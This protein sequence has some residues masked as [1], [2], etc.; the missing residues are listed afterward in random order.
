MLLNI[1]LTLDPAEYIIFRRLSP[2]QYNKSSVTL[3]T[4]FTLSRLKR[5][6]RTLREWDGPI[7]VTIYL[8]DATDIEQLV[9]YLATNPHIFDDLA[10]TIVKPDYSV[11]EAA[12][13]QRLRYPI[14]QLRNLA[15]E[16]APTLYV[17]VTDADFV[18]SPDMHHLLSTRGVPLITSSTLS[19]RSPTLLRTAVVIS[20]F[21][22]STSFTGAYP[23]NASELSALLTAH[24]PL[25]SLTDLNAGHGPSMPSLLFQPSPAHSLPPFTSTST[26]ATWAYE[27]C[28][29]P[30]WEPYYLLH[31]PSHPLY[32]ERFTDQ[33]GDKQSH[34]LLLNALGF[35]F[36][37]LRDVWFMHPP[38]GPAH[39]S[40]ELEKWPSARLVDPGEGRITDPAHFSE[41][42][43]DKKRFR[44]FE[45]FLP[46]LEQRFG[47][48]LRWPRGCSARVVGIRSFGK[49][50]AGS[51]FGM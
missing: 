20:A 11:N 43:L 5:F 28:F 7:S 51:I 2:R 17:L 4:Q 41:A 13:V 30:Q 23:T 26:P 21:V 9:D 8:T 34:T 39:E 47:W 44:Y 25:A 24:P 19:T 12:L 42:Q 14:N 29:E 15:L 48:N 38:K 10:L 1:D 46:E 16:I 18:P 45:D 22:L 36:K 3:V 32:D 35:E 40:A 33:G 37:V 6:E 49:S 27:V 50:S 31:R